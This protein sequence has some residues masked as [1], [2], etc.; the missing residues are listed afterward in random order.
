MADG[1]VHF[2][3]ETVNSGDTTKTLWYAFDR[4]DASSPF[5]IIGSLGTASGGESVALP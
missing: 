1:S 3:S 4:K 2:L 5:G